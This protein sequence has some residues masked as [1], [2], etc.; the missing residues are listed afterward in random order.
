MKSKILG[1]KSENIISSKYEVEVITLDLFIKEMNLQKI[2]IL[3]IDTEGHEM[4]C[5]IG[6]FSCNSH[7]IEYIQIEYHDDDMYKS[8]FSLSQFSDLFF[9]HGYHLQE[10]IKHGFGNFMDIIYK[11]I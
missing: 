2:D 6:L 1:L 8:S 5:L 10:S 3:K 7:N 11:K 4:N 9:F